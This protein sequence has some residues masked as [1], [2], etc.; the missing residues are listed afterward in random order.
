[1]PPRPLV[2]AYL[3]L[4][5]TLGI[6]LL[7]ASVRTCL[8]A[9]HGNAHGPGGVHLALLG[10]V[11]AVGALLFLIPRTLRVGGVILLV[12]FGIALSA[13]AV[14]REFPSQ[15]LLYTAGTI[16]VL[17]HGPVP[18]AWLRGANSTRRHA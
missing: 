1:M 2:Y 7:V 5:M 9:L 3:A 6:L 14:A 13:H 8:A 17:A 15:I 10:G 18:M 16:L 4:W 12:T 11:E